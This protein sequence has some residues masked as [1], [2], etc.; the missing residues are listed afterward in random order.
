MWTGKMFPTHY[1]IYYSSILVPIPTFDIYLSTHNAPFAKKKKII[2]KKRK[3]KIGSYQPL[4]Y[5]ITN[6]Y[7][8]IY[9]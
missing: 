6:I 8:D 5:I 9:T 7:I 2:K 3:N 1:N 4:T